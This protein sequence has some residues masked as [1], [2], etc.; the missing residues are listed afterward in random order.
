MIFK[1]CAEKVQITNEND[2]QVTFWKKLLM[3]TGHLTQKCVGRTINEYFCCEESETLHS[4][5]LQ[6]K[7]QRRC[8]LGL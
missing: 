4:S 6:Y 2:I 8:A 5:I 1:Q 3:I 7:S